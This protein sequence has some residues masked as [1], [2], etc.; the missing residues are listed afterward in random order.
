MKVSNQVQI[1]S[2]HSRAICDEIGERLR[3]ILRP[4][5]T[6]LPARLQIL[7]DRLADQ[8]RQMAPSIVPKL[9]DMICQ[10]APTVSRAA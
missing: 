2:V 7:I 3:T 5:E 6:G 1:D 10:P 8:D 9:D 4:T